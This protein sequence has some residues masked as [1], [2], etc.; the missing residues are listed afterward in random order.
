MN[1]EQEVD[2]RYTLATDEAYSYKG[3]QKSWLEKNIY[4]I[5]LHVNNGL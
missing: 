1:A 4:V 2:V 5:I 3:D